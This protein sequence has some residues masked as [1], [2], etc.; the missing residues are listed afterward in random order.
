MEQPVRVSLV[1]PRSGQQL[2]VL[3]PRYAVSETSLKDHGTYR[4][5]WEQDVRSDSEMGHQE[6]RS[7]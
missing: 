4:A 6:K 5:S 7:V 1:F 2:Y 3:V